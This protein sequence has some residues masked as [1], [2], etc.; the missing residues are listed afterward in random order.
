MDTSTSKKGSA[1]FQFT[2][3]PKSLEATLFPSPGALSQNGGLKHLQCFR[4]K[5][6]SYTFPGIVHGVWMLPCPPSISPC[7]ASC[8]VLSVL[9][10][11]S[12]RSS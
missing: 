7:S 11:A 6:H 10:S 2:W 8:M 12:W 3:A 5:S 1:I 9:C 4:A